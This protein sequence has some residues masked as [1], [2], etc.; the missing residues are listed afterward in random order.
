MLPGD[1]PSIFPIART[2]SASTISNGT[3][4]FRFDRGGLVVTGGISM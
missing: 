3:R 1:Q 4:T 2:L